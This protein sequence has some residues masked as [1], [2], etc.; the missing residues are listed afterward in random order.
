MDQLH[1]DEISGEKN[2]QAESVDF[3]IK[4]VFS[5]KYDVLSK[6]KIRGFKL[7]IP[8]AQTTLYFTVS[9]MIE[10]FV[11]SYILKIYSE[12]SNNAPLNVKADGLSVKTSIS[13]KNDNIVA[14]CDITVPEH[15]SYDMNDI[16]SD[17]KA[18]IN[19][20]FNNLPQLDDDS[21]ETNGN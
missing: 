17:F 21:G 12:N 1:K 4:I 14:E 10:E 5:D 20:K 15:I 18:M 16:L 13:I 2:M 6:K 19:N 7:K 3:G 9:G 8:K 11:T